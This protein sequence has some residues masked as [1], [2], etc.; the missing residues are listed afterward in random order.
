[1]KTRETREPEKRAAHLYTVYIY[2]IRDDNRQKRSDSFCQTEFFR[3]FSYSS[4]LC[5][6]LRRGWT[7]FSSH[8][9]RF[10]FFIIFF[11]RAIFPDHLI[12]TVV[13]NHK[14]AVESTYSPIGRWLKNRW[15]R[16]TR[17][18]KKAKENIRRE[19]L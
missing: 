11:V 1:V 15:V 8:I 7:P 12:V 5:A 2:C 3:F 4:G 14:T 17:L 9:F 10:L 16:Y 18:K 13:K 19:M 6:G